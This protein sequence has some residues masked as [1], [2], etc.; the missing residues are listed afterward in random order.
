MRRKPLI[1]FVFYNVLYLTIQ[2]IAE[3][4]QRFCADVHAFLYPM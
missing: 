4:I 3:R 1:F 2:C